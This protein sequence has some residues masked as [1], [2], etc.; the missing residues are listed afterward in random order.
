MRAILEAAYQWLVTRGLPT[1]IESTI[2]A[3]LSKM[4]QKDLSG[5]TLRRFLISPF[6]IQI[7]QHIFE[8]LLLARFF[9]ACWGYMDHVFRK[10]TSLIKEIDTYSK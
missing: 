1:T 8:C 9:A 5:L 6:P 3:F 4:L 2:E 7:I 10:L